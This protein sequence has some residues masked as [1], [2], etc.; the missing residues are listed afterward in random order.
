MLIPTPSQRT[1]EFLSSAGSAGCGF[2]EA[3]A[4]GAD[5]RVLSF[6]VKKGV[7]VEFSLLQQFSVY[8]AKS[9]L[10]YFLL[11]IDFSTF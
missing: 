4:L 5:G 1:S 10:Y 3:G 9:A 8:G 2:P 6:T 11:K 7:V